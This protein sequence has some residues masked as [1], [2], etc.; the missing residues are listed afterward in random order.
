MMLKFSFRTFAIS[1]L[2]SMKVRLCPCLFMS[3]IISLAPSTILDWN[4]AF[5]NVG[6]FIVVLVS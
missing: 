6:L 3:F 1:I 2:H 5:V 4:W